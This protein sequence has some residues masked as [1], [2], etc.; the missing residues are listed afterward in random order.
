MFKEQDAH[1]KTQEQN[2][3]PG[4]PRIRKW[5]ALRR[6]GCWCPGLSLTLT[7]A[8]LGFTA[9]CVWLCRLPS[10]DFLH[11]QYP[12]SSWENVLGSI[13]SWSARKKGKLPSSHEES[14]PNP[15]SYA[16]DFRHFRPTLVDTEVL[17][18]RETMRASQTDQKILKIVHII[19]ITIC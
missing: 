10:S 4:K 11:T 12:H 9:L 8:T 13:S 6:Q 7:W 14:T 1:D 3:E 5:E 19:I 16:M 18:A 17:R 2:A 15:F